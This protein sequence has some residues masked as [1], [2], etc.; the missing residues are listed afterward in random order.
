MPSLKIKLKADGLYVGNP[1]TEKDFIE[2]LKQSLK[3][4]GLSD[5]D[6]NSFLEMMGDTHPEEIRI[7]GELPAVEKI[8]ADFNENLSKMTFTLSNC[9]S[10][11]INI[12]I[13]SNKT[14][15]F[16]TVT[17][18]D[19]SQKIL[20]QDILTA[21]NNAGV[22][23]GI[24]IPRLREIEENNETPP[25][26]LIAK[27]IEA[28][29]GK[30]GELI[31]NFDAFGANKK[32]KLDE[33]G[34]ADYRMVDLYTS[35]KSGDVLC[36]VISGQEGL[37]G[38][39]VMGNEIPA[40]MGKTPSLPVGKDTLINPNKPNELISAIDGSPKL[41][42]NKV[43]VDPILDIRGDIGLA[44]GNVDFVGSIKITGKISEGFIVKSQGDVYVS[45]TCESVTIESGKDIILQHGIRAEPHAVL[46]AKGDVHAKFLEGATVIAGGDVVVEEYC[47]RC[48]IKAGS[49]VKVIGKKGYIAGGRISAQNN[50]IVKKLGSQAAPRTEV[51]VNFKS[52]Y[53]NIQLTPYQNQKLDNLMEKY[54]SLLEEI[55]SH[56]SELDSDSVENTENDKENVEEE[57][58]EINE[59]TALLHQKKKVIIEQLEEQ[60]SQ[61]V[62]HIRTFVPHFVEEAEDT[63]HFVAV[64]E[65]VHPNVMISIDNYHLTTRNEFCKLKFVNHGGKIVMEQYEPG[66][67]RA[68]LQ[69]ND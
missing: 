10:P 63:G 7:T 56:K 36:K 26:T 33:F 52:D 49:S 9:T 17:R 51:F 21:L 20:A 12:E 8:V 25:R 18:A 62:E 14:E 41:T 60:K 4:L 39:D 64:L 57:S 67:V 13:S 40:A 46:I 45:E 42:A 11:V 16:I 59:T 61:L 27:A 68:D 69:D 2:N 19:I 31:Y 34:N 58:T 53:A 47:Y 24:L 29:T 32:P 30:D 54:V 15:A 66:D 6:E 3:E 23:R 22:V 1:S 38:Y 37:P 5:F 65:I 55:K 35:V 48:D 43:H 50:V 28:V 44:T